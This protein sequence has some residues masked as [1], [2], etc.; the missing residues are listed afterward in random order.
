MTDS[1]RDRIAAADEKHS[2]VLMVNTGGWACACGEKFP[3]GAAAYREWRLHRA[4]AVI[5]AL[6]L[7]KEDEYNPYDPFP[8]PYRVR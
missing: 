6:G 5:E 2:Q 4:D 7:T 1:L 8:P 3:N